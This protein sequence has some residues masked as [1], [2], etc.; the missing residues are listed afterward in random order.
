MK[1]IMAFSCII[2]ILVVTGCATTK[3]DTK[4]GGTPHGNS[5]CNWLQKEP[6]VQGVVHGSRLYE[7]GCIALH[8]KTEEVVNLV[9]QP[10]DNGPTNKT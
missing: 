10:G 3:G 8:G 9:A 4:A 1:Q 6:F 5:T 7:L 2:L